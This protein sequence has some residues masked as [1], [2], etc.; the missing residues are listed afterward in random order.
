MSHTVE[1]ELNQP[2]IFLLAGLLALLAFIV[3]YTSGKHSSDL[4]AYR[5]GQEACMDW[6]RIDPYAEEAE[7][8]G[9]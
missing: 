8:H 4:E 3:G 2:M 9:L 5:E 1:I 7:A 6:Y